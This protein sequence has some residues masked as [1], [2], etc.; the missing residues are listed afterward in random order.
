MSDLICYSFPMFIETPCINF[1]RDHLFD[2]LFRFA[3]YGLFIYLTHCTIPVC[4]H[5]SIIVLYSLLWLNYSRLWTSNEPVLS[6]YSAYITKHIILR[7]T[8]EESGGSAEFRES[9]DSVD[10]SNFQ[11]SF[12][13]EME[14]KVLVIDQEKHEI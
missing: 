5:R 14:E 13:G 10:S 2:A 4:L 6:A 3:L 8:F 11:Q 12:E 7:E 1:T 9:F